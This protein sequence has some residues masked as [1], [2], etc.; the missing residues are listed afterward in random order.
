MSGSKYQKEIM[1]LLVATK[2]KGVA[3]VIIGGDKGDCYEVR[4]TDDRV[5]KALP[6]VLNNLALKVSDTLNLKEG[7]NEVR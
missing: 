7:E 3:I 5:F 4:A 2:A 1:D 6:G